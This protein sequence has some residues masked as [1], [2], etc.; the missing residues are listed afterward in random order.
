MG[1][2]YRGSASCRSTIVW[3]IYTPTHLASC[4]SLHLYM[5]SI[6][7]SRKSNL[8]YLK[9]ESLTFHAIAH[10]SDEKASPLNNHNAKKKKPISGKNSSHSSLDLNDEDALR[11]RAQRF[12]REHEIER[13]KS[14]Y[15]YNSPQ[16]THPTS[17]LLSRVQ[18]S[19]SASPA[20]W[21]R[22][23]EP[24]DRVSFPSPF[25]ESCS[26]QPADYGLGSFYYR[27]NESK[28]V[29]GLLKT[30]DCGFLFGRSDSY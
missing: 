13:Q 7:A 6:S 27:W 25:R 16:V 29:Q 20:S 5:A 9:K 1:C 24:E 28:L 17:T 21:T 12:E 8:L 30:D 14:M 3:C 18:N 23:D 15:G 19:R 11:R 10:N 2:S 22:G 4:R 26:R